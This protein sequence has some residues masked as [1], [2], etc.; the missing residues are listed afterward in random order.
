MSIRFLYIYERKFFGHIITSKWIRNSTNVLCKFRVNGYRIAQMFSVILAKIF[1]VVQL[2]TKVKFSNSL[3]RI[4]V[5]I[6]S[7]QLLTINK[8]LKT[9]YIIVWDFFQSVF[10]HRFG[11]EFQLLRIQQW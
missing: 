2:K 3:T 8:A 11:I 9:C 6:Y 10:F 4:E 1:S 7:I 5:H